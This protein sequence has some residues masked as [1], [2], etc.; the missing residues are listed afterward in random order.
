MGNFNV[1]IEAVQNK[2]YKILRDGI[3]FDDSVEAL[4][5]SVADDLGVVDIRVL[6]GRVNLQKETLG[7]LEIFTETLFSRDNLEISQIIPNVVDH[8]FMNHCM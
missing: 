6:G 3:Q 8:N 5:E 7:I 4:D 2:A 1:V